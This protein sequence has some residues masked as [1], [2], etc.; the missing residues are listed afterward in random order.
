MKKVILFIVLFLFTIFDVYASDNYEI[1]TEDNYG[2]PDYIMVTDD[3]KEA[4]L[5]TPLVD[6]DEKIYDFADKFSVKEEKKLYEK[7]QE[8]IKNYDIDMV[9]VTIM[10]NPKDSA[11]SYGQDFYD[12]NS[13]GIS[14]GHDGILLLFDFYYDRVS[15]VTTG[16]ASNLYNSRRINSIKNDIAEYITKDYYSAAV[17]FIDSSSSFADVGYTLED[18]SEPKLTGIKLF[19]R[20]PWMGIITFSVFT[21]IILTFILIRNKMSYVINTSYKKYLIKE[22]SKMTVVSEVLLN[23]NNQI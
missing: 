7:V 18:G 20:L 11:T 5:S 21:A 15:I 10:N 3:N 4:I 13:F 23:E 2:V 8:Y 19:K 16:K 9:I 14:E 22:N 17:A 6:S 12:Y 1:R